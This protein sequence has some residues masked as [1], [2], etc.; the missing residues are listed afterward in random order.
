M[1][2][3][4]V[5]LPL[6]TNQTERHAPTEAAIALKSM[7]KQLDVSARARYTGFVPC[8]DG[9]EHVGSDKNLRLAYL[10]E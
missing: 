3:L 5:S 6:Y 4:G 10:T 2:D 7:Q 9:D 1:E 8:T